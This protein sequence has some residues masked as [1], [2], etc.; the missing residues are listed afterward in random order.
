MIT[1]PITGQLVRLYRAGRSLREIA[2][3]VRC[4]DRTVRRRLLDAN[5]KLRPRGGPNHRKRPA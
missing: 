1:R 3:M 2:A 5:V 4:S